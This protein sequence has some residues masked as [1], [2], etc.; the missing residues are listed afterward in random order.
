MFNVPDGDTTNQPPPPPGDQIQLEISTGRVMEWLGGLFGNEWESPAGGGGTGGQFMFASIDDLN[1][2]IA[3]W[4]TEY[5]AI[6]ADGQT[7]DQAAGYVM[8]P[9]KDSM[10]VG[11]AK[12]TKDSLL[13]LKTHNEAMRQYAEQY[14]AKL[15]ASRD[16]ILNTEQN[17]QAQL[18]NADGRG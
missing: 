4:Q 15:V 14:I 3:Q 6:M 13:S 5:E 9:A 8:P 16:S 12:A 18:R 17:N 10:S 7:I 1:A 11:Q 2:V